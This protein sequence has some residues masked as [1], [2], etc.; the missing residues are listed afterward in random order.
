MT[1][2][3]YLERR[4]FNAGYMRGR[5][6]AMSLSWD[7]SRYTTDIKA[8]HWEEYRSQPVQFELPLEEPHEQNGK[9]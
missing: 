4:A 8:Q 1:T 5:H 3:E 2:T 6:D 7:P 9:V